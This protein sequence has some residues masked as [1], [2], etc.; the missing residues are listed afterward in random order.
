MSSNLGKFLLISE[1][2][3]L[4]IAITDLLLIKTTFFQFFKCYWVGSKEIDF[5]PTTLDV[6]RISPYI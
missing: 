5:D 1:P 4:E 6:N 3:P 2:I